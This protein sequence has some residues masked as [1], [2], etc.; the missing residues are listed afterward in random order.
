MCKRL[1]SVPMIDSSFGLTTHFPKRHR[2]FVS[3]SQGVPSMTSG[4]VRVYL[5]LLEEMHESLHRS[6]SV[7][8]SNKSLFSGGKI[9]VQ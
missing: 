5:T 1:Y 4:A 7:T 2:S 3:L 6:A 9:Q 8:E